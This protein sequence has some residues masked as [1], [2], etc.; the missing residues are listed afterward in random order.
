MNGRLTSSSDAIGLTRAASGRRRASCWTVMMEGPFRTRCAIQRTTSRC[1]YGLSECCN[2]CRSLCRLHLLITPIALFCW[3]AVEERTMPHGSSS[4][5]EL[6]PSLVHDP[7]SAAQFIDASIRSFG[8]SNTWFDDLYDARCASSTSSYPR[9]DPSAFTPGDLVLAT[10]EFVR[11]RRP[12]MSTRGG[13]PSWCCGLK[14]K[15]L[16]LLT[17]PSSHAVE[18]N[19]VVVHP[20]IV[21]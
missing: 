9:V 5:I 1:T 3:R 17:K 19:P 20:E 18:L 21:M 10:C 12:R 16:D 7:F 6:N 15:T 4:S 11:W 8:E 13:W 14:L 2:L